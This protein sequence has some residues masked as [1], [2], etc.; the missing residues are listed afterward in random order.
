MC[1]ER[2]QPLPESIKNAPRLLEGLGFY[3]TAFQEL[4]TDRPV[5]MGVGQ[6]PW[7]SID[8]FAERHGL[9]EE[10]YDSFL[11]LIRRMDEEFMDHANAQASKGDES[12][13]LGAK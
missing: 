4:S 10:E 13:G 1:I 8:R 12:E 7:T 2:R 6:I 3:Y 9:E 5:G 11:Y